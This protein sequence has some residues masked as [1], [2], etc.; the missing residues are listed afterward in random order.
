MAG[1]SL[2]CRAGFAFC[3]RFFPRQKIINA[4]RAKPV[5]PPMSNGTQFNSAQTF[6]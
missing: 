3:L 1:V 5:K 2:R 6:Q 4:K